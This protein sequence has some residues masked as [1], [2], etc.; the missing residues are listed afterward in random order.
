MSFSGGRSHVPLIR[1][2]QQNAEDY[3]DEYE[4]D[5]EEEPLSVALRPQLST[6][7]ERSEH[8]EDSKDWPR[9]RTVSSFSTVDYG[10]II[11]RPPQDPN[12]IPPSP[13]LSA[14]ERLSFQEKPPSPDTSGSRTPTPTAQPLAQQSV[15][16]SLPEIPDYNSK[17]SR[18]Q[19]SLLL[20][21]A[22][23]R[24]SERSRASTSTD[25][26]T[27]TK[28]RSKLSELASSRLS[29]VS[30]RS[31]RSNADGSASVV[32]YPALRPSRESTLSLNSDAESSLTGSSSL[33]RHVERALQTAL[34]LEAADQAMTNQVSEAGASPTPSSV[35]STPMTPR[36][37]SIPAAAESVS[38]KSPPLSASE[39]SSPGAL[40]KPQ[41]KLAMLAQAKAHQG[42]W[43]P[44]PKKPSSSSGGLSLRPTH[45][46]YLTPIANG[47]TAT[48]AITTTYQTLNDLAKLPPLPP[49][50]PPP[51]R[52]AGESKELKG[53][54][55]S[56][57][58][59]KSKRAHQKSEPDPELDPIDLGPELVMFAP[60]STRSRASPSAFA[61]LLIDDETS[62]PSQ[63]AS[64][65]LRKEHKSRD[66]SDKPKHRHR[67]RHEPPLPPAPHS[68]AHKFAFD[69]P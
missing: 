10:R 24:L 19:E 60:K 30:T 39:A 15:A 16:E 50:Y 5:E 37:R 13:P 1:L 44:K 40:G 6:I 48:T 17:S 69:V 66:L 2:A 62:S 32:T 27:V 46:E 57:L 21:K 63:D 3:I 22:S 11:E 36:T 55:P 67:H 31:S 68:P 7:S 64:D 47:P 41:S 52:A 23:S 56:K 29:S 53:P 65:K 43:M 38:P 59:M 35:S 61:S 25:Q 33:T 14:L 26:H 12:E 28:S 9:P 42:H 54:K 4:Y 45:T 34:E 49:S 18:P 8:T 51:A 58:A 20:K